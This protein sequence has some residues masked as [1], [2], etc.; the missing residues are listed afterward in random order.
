[1]RSN[2]VPLR[3][4]R[5]AAGF[6][7][8]ELIVAVG[9]VALLTVGIGQIFRSVGRLTGQGQALAETDQQARQIER[10]LR[11][12]IEAY[13]RLAPDKAF[14]AIRMREV[15]DVNRDGVVTAADGE[16]PIYVT[17][18]DL[19]SDAQTGLL[20]YTT[21]GTAGQRNP[22]RSRAITTRVDEVVFPGVA[23]SDKP[24]VS[25]QPM[26]ETSTIAPAPAPTAPAARIAWGH[27]LRPRA[28]RDNARD[29]NPVAAA[30][31]QPQWPWIPDGDFGASANN[32][33]IATL[34]PEQINPALLGTYGG[35]TVSAYPSAGR[36]QFAGSW[37]LARQALLL[38]GGDAAGAIDR[39][40]PGNP[41][42]PTG[43]GRTYAPYIRDIDA[44]KRFGLSLDRYAPST[45]DRRAAMIFSGRTDVCAQS[46]DDAQRWLE[47]EA[48]PPAVS[49]GVSPRPAFAGAFSTGWW[50][51]DRLGRDSG[52]FAPNTPALGGFPA[53]VVNKP[54]WQRVTAAP[55]GFSSV[56]AYNAFQLRTALA[57]VF[58][59]LIA[60]SEP[61]PIQ[62]L[63]NNSPTQIP[64]PE[65]AAMDTHAAF[66]GRCSRFE[67]A[68][69]NGARATADIFRPGS[70][71]EVLYRPGDLI[72]FDISPLE[73]AGGQV[74]VRNTYDSWLFS[75]PLQEARERTTGLIPRTVG[76]G[77]G[78]Y[79]NDNPRAE[80]PGDPLARTTGD[81]PDSTQSR[82]RLLLRLPQGQQVSANDASA[83]YE[84]AIS[85]GDPGRGSAFN[86]NE[87]LALWPYRLPGPDGEYGDAWPKP[88]HVRVRITLHDSQNR[89]SERLPDGTTRPGRTY[90]FIFALGPAEPS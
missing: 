6:T 46:I 28:V 80:V 38:V 65:H 59:R 60:E 72:F 24:Y 62:R 86:S 44:W 15:G 61:P 40:P 10:Q 33:Q 17:R 31:I 16:R 70:T 49:T 32:P 9:A 11:E 84:A 37:I 56:E 1:M 66:T 90:E 73:I 30:S 42:Y 75:T 85:G 26:V 45:S 23:P 74:V 68:W 43:Q 64:P 27:A 4:R 78:G 29:A 7:L 25:A 35:V 13:N 22:P 36:N 39:L 3:T 50:G 88:T 83:V 87:L 47:G 58:A 67:V 57:G 19:E 69:S 34:S 71:T 53:G 55:S 41:T 21:A 77:S 82:Q 2:P 54:L 8:T 89:L 81:P 18:E 20:P 63:F 14:F 12:D 5:G 52:F 48:Q 79:T 51:A 76:A